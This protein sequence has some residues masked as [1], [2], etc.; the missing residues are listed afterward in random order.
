MSSAIAGETQAPEAEG[1]ADGD[2]HGRG[3]REQ[4]SRDPEAAVARL[5]GGDRGEG[6]GCDDGEGDV[7]ADR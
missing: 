1:G 4:E 3:G 5:G 6:V 2:R 7:V